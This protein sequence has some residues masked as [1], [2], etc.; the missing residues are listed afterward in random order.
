MSDSAP[1]YP[2]HAAD[3]IMAVEVFTEVLAATD[4][5]QLGEKLTEQLRE[6]TG[7][8]TVMVITHEKE[9]YA[10]ALLHACPT[11]RASLFSAAD[12]DLLCPTNSPEL[13]PSRVAAFPPDHPLRA[14]LLRAGI[15]SLLRIPLHAGS[16]LVG[17]LLLLDL[18]ALERI[19]EME[20]IVTHLS[21][22][23]AL[24]L[25]NALAHRRIEQ[26]AQQ[27]D[28][29]TRE[30]E[31]RVAERTAAL[32]QEIT[33]RKRNEQIMHARLRLLKFAESHTM[34][35]LLTATLDEIEVLTGS[36]IG[37]YHFVEADQQTLTLHSWSTNTINNMC[38]AEGSG[39]HYDVDQAG[40]WADCVRQRRPLIHND[41]ASLPGRKGMPEGHATVIREVVVPIF[42]GEQIVAIV[43]VG[44]KPTHYVEIDIEIVSQLGDLSW[45][46]AERMRVQGE[47][48]QLNQQLEQRVSDRTEQLEAV[49]KELEAFSYSVSHD[50]RAPLRAI[51]GFSLIL[52]EEYTEVLDEEGRRLLN[53]VRDN[54]AR[55]G[56]LIDDILKFSRTGRLE[57]SFSEIDMEKMARAVCAELLAADSENKLQWEIEPIPPAR[58]DNSMLRQVFVNLLSNA[59]KFS[60]NQETPLIKVGARVEENETV[61]YVKDNGVGFDMRYV[62]RLFGVFQRLH[63]VDEFEGSGIGL[64]IV[65]RIVSRHG[66]RVWAQSK[67]NEGS[68]IY[69]A[70]PH[71]EGE[72]VRRA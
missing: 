46:V 6:L 8:R 5:S 22:V 45:D 11:R 64:A 32:Q 70:L 54:T 60:R 69:F 15:E 30:L 52:L 7:A 33:E 17:M 67:L 31:Q 36:T 71:V 13:I 35:E 40:V 59:I 58:G 55:M 3:Q 1:R 28:V 48:R 56:Q 4:A 14:L 23:L 50:L 42:R 61:Y 26:Q 37:F 62:D 25:R 43:G 18:P 39:S 12:F 9:P 66:G 57:I 47:I 2:N 44:N 41:Y 53:V 29:Q 51:D 72:D 27:L 68:T 24:A 19:D 10:H 20:R 38:T 21:P 16:R 34:D 65:K 63:T 49:N